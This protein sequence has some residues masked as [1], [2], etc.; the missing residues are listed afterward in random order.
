MIALNPA[1]SVRAKTITA[2]ATTGANGV[3]TTS[4][5]SLCPTTCI[6]A[7]SGTAY[8]G[9]VSAAF[10]GDTSYAA[11]TGSFGVPARTA[12]V[13]VV[14]SQAPAVTATAP[15]ATA[16]TTATTVS[17]APTQA[18]ATLAPTLAAATSPAAASP[19]ATTAPQDGVES[20]TPADLTALLHLGGTTHTNAGDY[21]TDGW[22]F[23]GNGNYKATTGTVHDF[24]DKADAVISVTPYSIT[25][26]GNPH[27]GT[28]TATGAGSL[29]QSLTV[30]YTG[31]V[32]GDTPATFGVS[33]NVT[34]TLSTVGPWGSKR[35]LVHLGR[36]AATALGWR[37][38]G[39]GSRVTSINPTSPYSTIASTRSAAMAT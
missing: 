11:A 33:P 25:Y 31:L 24:I 6:S 35:P 3:A 15:S 34:A 22:T 39:T 36:V 18:V 32:N 5:Q 28:A 12:A 9:A 16:T 10:A 21:T 17:T 29:S 2:S 30:T 1:E 7:N 14:L 23:D 37:L 38:P 27:G 26:D 8:T 20:P 13:F 19:V 4:A